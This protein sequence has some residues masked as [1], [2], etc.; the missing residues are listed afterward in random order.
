MF[1]GGEK[2]VRS[3]Y[4]FL[5]FLYILVTRMTHMEIVFM[6]PIKIVVNKDA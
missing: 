5:S 3:S 4:M 1:P 6:C 2:K